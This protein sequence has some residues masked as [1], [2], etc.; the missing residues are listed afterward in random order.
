[1]VFD[2]PFVYL[3]GLGGGIYGAYLIT[4]FAIGSD[5]QVGYKNLENK[6]E[7]GLSRV[8]GLVFGIVMVCGSMAEPFLR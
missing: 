2:D 4:A 5:M 1:M 8:F 6:I 3:A 7:N